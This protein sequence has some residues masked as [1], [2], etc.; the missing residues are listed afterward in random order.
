MESNGRQ[1]G[2]STKPTVVKEGTKDRD[3]EGGGEIA[4]PKKSYRG[5]YKKVMLHGIPYINVTKSYKGTEVRSFL[6]LYRKKYYE[7]VR[8]VNRVRANNQKQK[9]KKK[10]QITKYKFKIKDTI[11]LLNKEKQRTEKIK[12]AFNRKLEA[13]RE[14]LHKFIVQEKRKIRKEERDKVKYKYID[15]DSNTNPR[16]YD[17]I[18]W[19]RIYTKI[20]IIRRRTKLKSQEVLILLWIYSN[21]EGM[22]KNRMWV[23][24]TGLTK[25]YIHKYTQRLI[26]FNLV[27]K[28]KIKNRYTFD[29]TERGSKFIIPIVEFIKIQQVNAKRVKRKFVRN[30]V[31]TAEATSSIQDG[32]EPVQQEGAALPIHGDS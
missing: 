12:K 29:L 22:S 25:V 26:E 24:E 21:G 30:R 18:T 6:A 31:S 10:Q 16:N 4:K 17:I 32:G 2:R 3:G 28:E 15:T 27:K 1:Q 14:K 5:I 7:Q 11:F 9:D 23:L 13:E 8:E 20:N 19:I